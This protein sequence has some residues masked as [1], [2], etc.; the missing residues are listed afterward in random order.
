L[1]ALARISRLIRREVVTFGGSRP[2]GGDRSSADARRARTGLGRADR[3]PAAR[4]PGRAGALAGRGRGPGG[5]VG[6]RRRAGGGPGPVGGRRSAGGGPRR[7]ARRAARRRPRPPGE[8]HGP[9]ARRGA[10]R[11]GGR[12]AGRRRLLGP[13]AAAAMSRER[14]Q[15]TVELVAMLPL[16]LAVVLAVV[17]LLLAGAASEYAGHAA[18]AGAVALLE[19]ADPVAAAREAIPGWS[20]SRVDV[21][22]RGGVV[23]VAVEPAALVPPLAAAM[24]AHA[25][26]RA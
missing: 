10:A 14:G 7:R 24:T 1:R 15:S 11:P 25:Q 21:V 17:Q 13:A 12:V 4:R 3:D 22:V 8:R 23:R 20:R 18:E 9:R 16:L 19:G 2:T 5:V 26:A 6:R